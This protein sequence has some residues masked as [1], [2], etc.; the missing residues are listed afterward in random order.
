LK[1]GCDDREH[2]Y[3]WP[4]TNL[5]TICRVPSRRSSTSGIRTPL[6]VRHYLKRIETSLEQ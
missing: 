6:S 2:L 5:M 4:P 1:C 3:R